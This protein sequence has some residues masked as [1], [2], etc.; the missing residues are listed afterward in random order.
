MAYDDTLSEWKGVEGAGK[1]GCKSK[2]ARRGWGCVVVE[3][4][5]HMKTYSSLGNSLEMFERGVWGVSPQSLK[6]ILKYGLCPGNFLQPEGKICV[7]QIRS[8]SRGLDFG[9]MKRK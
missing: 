3:L 8:K 9:N 2:S 6:K 4:N 1:E 7:I 5:L